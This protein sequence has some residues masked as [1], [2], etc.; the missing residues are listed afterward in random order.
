MY[1]AYESLDDKLKERIAGLRCV[2]DASRNSTGE[3]RV[4]YKEV[5]DPRETVGA[6]HPLVRTHPVTGRKCLLLGRRRGAYVV[7]LPLEDSEALLDA[8]WK[9][10][11]NPALTW[12]QQWQLG[13][14]ILWDNRCTMHRRE[15]FDP[16]TRRI[17]FR[18]QIRGEA[19][20]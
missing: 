2:H 15:G 9:H 14:A 10:A 20:A 13:D 7:G 17:M 11:T 6:I 18:T 8:L 5:T 4:G 3:L 16:T 12:T 19:V 1:A